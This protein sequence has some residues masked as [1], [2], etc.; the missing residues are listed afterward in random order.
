MSTGRKTLVAAGLM[1][2]G[3]LSAHA[4]STVT[5]YGILDAGITY[6][7]NAA[8]STGH[9]SL[10]EYG[11]GVAQ[12]SRWGMRGTEDLGNGLHAVFTLEN[13]F[14]TGNGTFAQ[15]GAEFGRQAFVGLSKDGI[16]SLTFG[17]QYA[18]STEYLGTYYSMGGATVVG[19]FAFH[20][21]ALDQ[22]TATQ[23]NNTIKFSSADLHGLKFGALYGFSNQAGA[24][25]G[26]APTANPVNAGSSRTY[27][28]GFNYDYGKLGL[29]GAYTNIGNPNAATPAFTTTIA[30]VN[31]QANKDLWTLGFGLRYVFGPLLAFGNWTDTH[32]IPLT[33]RSSVLTSYEI[34]GSYSFTPALSFAL[35]DSYSSLTGGFNGHWNQINSGLDYALSKRTDVYALVVYQKATGTNTING[36]VVPVQAEIGAATTFTANSGVGAS[37]QLAARVGIRHR[38]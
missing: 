37:S 31:T 16:G 20:P 10:L 30:N 24:F 34:G 15:G 9:S 7:N 2:F 19:N 28:F 14:N 6:V 27:S 4:Q 22:E 13:G 17:R 33:G 5:I 32:L 38:F 21:N 25:A 23:L 29:S 11:N 35:G 36:K 8:I 12:A 1:S 18:F 26:S 3:C